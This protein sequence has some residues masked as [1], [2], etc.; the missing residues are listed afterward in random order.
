MNCRQ[1][2]R[3]VR[4]L[5]DGE[6]ASREALDEHVGACA[7][8]RG[9]LDSM[10]RLDAALG[11]ALG[12]AVSDAE[13]DRATAIAMPET[14]RGWRPVPLLSRLAPA[15][16]VLAL[17]LGFL[18]G[19]AL[20]PRE[21]LVERA[22]EKPVITVR[23]IEVPVTKERVVV[24]EVPVERV[25]VVYR[26]R[27]VEVSRPTRVESSQRPVKLDEVVIRIDA[28]SELAPPVVSSEIRPVTV[29]GP[30]SPAPPPEEPRRGAES[31]SA[32]RRVACRAVG[33]EL[34]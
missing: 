23:R 25:R 20:W 10:L 31:G 24:R 26:E 12:S 2:R 34:P 11:A 30:E 7:E 14:W 1:A 16:S 21:R 19:H 15:L 6:A 22:V 32:G 27:V 13:T 4:Q 5:L 28:R 18:G 8:C 3:V 17:L 33:A 9:Y 29:V